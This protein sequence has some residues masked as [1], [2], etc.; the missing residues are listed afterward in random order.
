MTISS[1]RLSVSGKPCDYCNETAVVAFEDEAINFIYRTCSVHEMLFT[2]DERTK[3]LAGR[4]LMDTRL[5]ERAGR[6]WQAEMRSMMHLVSPHYADIA[7]ALP[8]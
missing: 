2:A 3:D 5:N 4:F 1:Y 6:D 7:R 8:C